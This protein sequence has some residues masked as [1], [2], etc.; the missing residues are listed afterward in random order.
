MNKF[1]LLQHYYNKDFLQNSVE[2]DTLGDG[3]VADDLA[4][5]YET[6]AFLAR[7]VGMGGCRSIEEFIQMVD[8]TNTQ[9]LEAFQF[10][11][12]MQIGMSNAEEKDLRDI[13]EPNDETTFED[14]VQA[15]FPELQGNTADDSFN[16]H[17]GFGTVHVEPKMKKSEENEVKEVKPVPEPKVNS[18][19][20]EQPDKTIT[21]EQWFKQGGANTGTN[22]KIKG[23]LL[24]NDVSQKEIAEYEEK[25]ARGEIQLPNYD[26]SKMSGSTLR[27]LSPE[28]FQEFMRATM[29]YTAKGKN[30]KVGIGDFGKSKE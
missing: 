17:N 22:A 23:F 6:A 27:N 2:N 12:S 30:F 29:D 7:T 11:I 8:D 24:N 26:F 19:I 10:F 20:K 14:A 25:V 21:R 3:E 4:S 13:G 16:I 28:K 1:Q 15:Y 5:L 9:T 18:P